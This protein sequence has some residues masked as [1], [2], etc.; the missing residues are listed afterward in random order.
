[1][2]IF[3]ES[4]NIVWVLR[5]KTKIF[6][7]LVIFLVSVFGETPLKK[8]DFYSFM[9]DC[10]KV[11][12]SSCFSP[13]RNSEGATECTQRSSRHHRRRRAPLLLF[14]IWSVLAR[15]GRRLFSSLSFRTEVRT[16]LRTSPPRKRARWER[17]GENERWISGI[18]LRAKERRREKHLNIFQIRERDF[19]FCLFVY[20][21]NFSPRLLKFDV[22]KKL[23]YIMFFCRVHLLL[24]DSDFTPT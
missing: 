8:G 10:N 2:F 20:S 18:K 7:F 19:S 9:S 15:A 4:L 13:W 12:P 24:L 6:L 21:G 11:W 22:L 14:K 16:R 5:R 1:M 23:F 3:G 17:K